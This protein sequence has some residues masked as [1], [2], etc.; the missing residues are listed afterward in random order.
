MIPFP[1]K[2]YQIIYADPPWTMKMG[3][4]RTNSDTPKGRWEGYD[5]IHQLPY[6]T[7][8]L[9]EIGNLPVK[10]ISDKNSVLFL[11]TINKY[12]KQSYEIANM[13]GFSPST[14]IVWCKSPMGLGMGGVFVQT[15][16]YLLMCRRGTVKRKKRIDT[17]WFQH[18][19]GKHSKKP[20]MFRDMIVDVFGDLPRIEL[21]AR[22]KTDG[23]DVWGNEV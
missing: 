13:W 18:K 14:M 3:N 5:N 8:S 15:T 7:M 19:R 23:W 12:I 10:Q 9:E 21:F 22:Q 1:D 11:W 4:T 2:K 20:D 17:T 6:S 16:E